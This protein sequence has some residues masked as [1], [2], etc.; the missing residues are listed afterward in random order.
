MSGTRPAARSRPLYRPPRHEACGQG[1]ADRRGAAADAQDEHHSRRLADG[2]VRADPRQRP[3]RSVAVLEGSQHA[4]LRLQQAGRKALGG[5]A[6]IFLA[7]EHD[8]RLSCFLLLYQ[9]IFGNGSHEDL[10]KFDVPTLIMHGD[11]D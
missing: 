5:R 6:R 4:V 11:D 8:G 1:R 2:G 7:P 3:C 9:G 10:K